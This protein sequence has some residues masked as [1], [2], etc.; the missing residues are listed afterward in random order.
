MTS[1][2]IVKFLTIKWGDK[3][4]PEYVNR[5]YNN[6]KN[7]YL[8]PF[9]FYCITDDKEG[10]ECPTYSF[11]EINV[12]ETECFTAEKVTFFKSKYLP[13]E[14]PYVMMDLDVIVLRD[15]KPY[16]DQY[17]FNEPRMIKNYWADDSRMLISYHRGDCFINSSF[18]TWD[19]DQLEWLYDLIVGNH[20][21]ANYKFKSF[22]KFIT[23]C[24]P[25][26][27]M[28]Y[29]PKGIV[30]TYSFGAEYPNDLEKEKFRP[31]YYIV[32]FNT[33]HMF[34]DGRKIVSDEMEGKELHE[35][36]EWVQRIWRTGIVDQERD[37]TSS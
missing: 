7:T 27:K 16:F 10:L 24:S 32:L 25:R 33:S 5:L 23:Y 11:D 37:T 28:K 34:V 26:D 15:L 36:A 9:E 6:I 17:G 21:I 35:A 3:Y 29:H 31:E 22:D 1:T 18:V 30:Y 14:G 8:G 4:G 2:T 12:Y 20:D 13:F 19:G